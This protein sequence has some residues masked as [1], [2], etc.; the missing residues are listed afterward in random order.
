M[1][2]LKCGVV[3]SSVFIVA[4]SLGA[5]ASGPPSHNGADSGYDH[6]RFLPGP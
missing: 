5:C 3:L 1:T 6:F 2:Q 4:M